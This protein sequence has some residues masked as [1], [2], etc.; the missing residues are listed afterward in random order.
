MDNRLVQFLKDRKVSKGEPFTHTSMLKPRGRFSIA[1]DDVDA[2]FTL[3]NN[4]IEEGGIAG[5]TE[6]PD[7]VVPLIVDIDF[8]CPLDKGLKR[9]YKPKHIKQ[10]VSIYQEIITEIARNPTE[11]MLYCCV[12]EKTAPVSSRGQCKDGFH[13]HFPHFYTEHWVQKEYIRSQA[14]SRTMERKILEDI[15]MLEPLEKV[16]DKNIPSVVW[17]MY[18]SRKETGAES[19]QLTKRYNKDLELIPLKTVFR[20]APDNGATRMWNLPRYLSVQRGLEAI[21]LHKDVVKQ[22]PKQVFRRKKEYQRELSA[23][24]ADLV[25]AEQLLEMLDDDRA[26]DYIQWMEIGWV[27]FNISEGHEKGLDLWITFSGRSEKFEDGICDKEWAKMEIRNYTLGT[28]Q[29]F[30]RNDSPSEFNAWKDARVNHELEQGIS[31]AENDV[32]QILY[33]MFKNQYVC[34]DVEKDIWYEFKKHRWVRTPK[35]ITLRSNMSHSLAN[36]YSELAGKY[37]T[38]LQET[39]DTTEKQ[40]LNA[41]VILI[42]RLVEKL[43]NN[44]F[45]NAVMKEAM[46]YFFDSTFVEKMDENPNLLVCENGVYDAENRI[47]RDGRPEDY[48]TK[49]TGIYYHEFEDD[50]P[51]V[52]ELEEILKKMFPDPK[53]FKFFKQTTSDLIKGGNRHKIFVIWTGDGDNGKSVCADFIEKALGEYYYTPPTSLLTGKQSQSDSATAALLPCKGARAVVVSETDNTDV[54]NCGTMKKLTGGDPFYARGLF[55][56]PT[57]VHPLFKVILHC[58]KLPIV[59]AEDKASWNRIRVLPFD[60]TFVK[61]EQAPKS[62]EKQYQK[63]KFPMNK[64][65]KDRLDSLAETFLWWMIKEFEAFGDSDLYEPE[66]VS[67]ATDTYHKTNDFYLQF[68][69]EQIR[70]TKKKDDFVTL[71]VLYTLFKNWYKEAYPGRKIPTRQMVKEDMEKKLGK[72][73]K[74]VWRGV[75]TFNPDEELSEDEESSSDEE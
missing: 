32:A 37:T 24:F 4:V 25:I 19:Y 52:I 16:F 72:Q 27:L 58:N 15:P 40:M 67:M 64:G 31:A 23:I 51:R 7:S 43:K 13:L 46:E 33:M 17:M 60:S 14:I 50:D 5:L 53:I 35:G 69:D 10:I 1:G 47:F 57:K 42:M 54:M 22:K 74:G 68:L 55:K 61:A 75:T 44:R 56:E 62:L 6:K 65:L 34:A 70:I 8:R 20:R 49:T 63:K 39:G 18:G 11:K 21:P 12:L 41:K 66:A 71:T 30:A 28:L 3:Y 36:K 59:S 73:V 38:K 26:E 9:H 2:F 45:K 48:C 29:H